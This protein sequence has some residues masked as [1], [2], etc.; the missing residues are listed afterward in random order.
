MIVA[1]GTAVGTIGLWSRKLPEGV[2]IV[3]YSISPQRRRRGYA[4]DA[5]KA[6][7]EFA[8]TVPGIE[9]IELYIEPWNR[10]SRRAAE[11]AGY[12]CEGLLPA[13]HEV[14][15]VL[16]DMLLYVSP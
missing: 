6:I 7:T 16:K 1:D 2:G 3:G 13:H 12:R 5:L 8:W 14:G 15:G 10:G 11:K 9:R 4:T